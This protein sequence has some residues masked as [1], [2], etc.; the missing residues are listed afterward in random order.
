MWWRLGNDGYRRP[1]ELLADLDVHRAAASRRTGGARIADGRLAAL[2]RRVE[3]FGFHLAKL[4]VR[5]HADEVRE[6]TDAHARASSPRSRR[7]GDA[8]ARARSTR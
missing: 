3:L 2:E 8:T 1:D 5:L 4:D 6:P 7:R